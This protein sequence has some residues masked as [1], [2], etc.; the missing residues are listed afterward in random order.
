[1]LSNAVI[2]SSRGRLYSGPFAL[3]VIT[4]KRR[5]VGKRVSTYDLQAVGV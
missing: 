1:M 5:E 2:F 3:S 4:R